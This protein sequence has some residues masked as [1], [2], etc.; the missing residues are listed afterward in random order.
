MP[1]SLATLLVLLSAAPV[2][3]EAPRPF[4]A[5]E[6]T[7]FRERIQPELGASG[8]WIVQ[9]VVGAFG[10]NR[11]DADVITEPFRAS[12][13]FCLAPSVMY[14]ASEYAGPESAEWEFVTPSARYYA[15]DEPLTEGCTGLSLESAFRLSEKVDTDT[16]A[17]IVDSRASLVSEGLDR[18]ADGS[19]WTPPAIAAFTL[20]SVGLR[21]DKKRPGIQYAA[22]YMTSEC[23]GVS[24]YFR[25]VRGEIAV[26][27]AF[28]VM[29]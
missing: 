23:S 18:L 10:E 17:F 25:I 27:D 16:L 5:Q 21:H 22:R 1:V 3:P 19:D 13:R 28:Q 8:I 7:T 14:E 9:G 15:W 11:A 2:P 6:E 12:E 4:T 24:V 29:C 20:R 26:V